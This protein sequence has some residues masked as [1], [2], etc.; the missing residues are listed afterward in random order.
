LKIG[1]EVNK[2]KKKENEPG[3][4]RARGP[5]ET[6]EGRFVPPEREN[7]NVLIEMRRREKRGA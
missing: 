4:S 7:Y 1:T 3:T 5:P 2:R 6:E